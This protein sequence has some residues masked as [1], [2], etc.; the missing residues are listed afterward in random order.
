MTTL[1]RRHLLRGHWRHAVAERRPPW[2]L[3]ES[4]FVAGCSRC[5]ACITQCESGVLVVG[6]GGFPTL[7]FSR[8]ECTFCRRCADACPQP[9]FHPA[10]QRP[11]RLHVEIQAHCLAQCGIEC[12]SC[13]DGCEPRAIIFIPRPGSVAALRLAPERC[14]GCGA[15]IAAC[16]VDALRMVESATPSE[17]KEA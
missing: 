16:P 7:D 12:R 3:E 9:L 2:A 13:Q 11:W 4:A 17:V 14:S 8:A 10:D 5:H 1:S 15:C 6:Q